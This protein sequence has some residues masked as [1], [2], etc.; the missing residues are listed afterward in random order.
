M[1]RDLAIW[2]VP[3]IV[4]PPTVRSYYLY[5]FIMLIFNFSFEYLQ[6]IQRFRSFFD[7]INITISG[8]IICECYERVIAIHTFHRKWSTNIS[9]NDFS[10]SCATV[11]T[12]FD[13]FYILS[14]NA[15]YALL[16]V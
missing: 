1:S 9:V 8:V 13:L 10:C 7:W 12:L 4:L 5:S 6:F 16:Y 15:I 3:T 2:S 11:C 14:F